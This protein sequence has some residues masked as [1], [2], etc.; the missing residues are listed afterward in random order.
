MFDDERESI[1]FQV[2]KSYHLCVSRL[3]AIMAWSYAAGL[4]LLSCIGANA[5]IHNI[6]AAGAIPDVTDTATMWK[7]G[8]IL[9]NT[10]ALLKSGDTLL[11]PNKTF[12]LYGGITGSGFS[13]VTFQIDGTLSYAN[14]RKTWPADANGNVLQC[15]YFSN[16]ENVLFTSN[17]TGTFDGNGAAWWGAIKYLKY[18]GSYDFS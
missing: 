8:G 6:E 15:M 17:G 12:H 1:S 18:A 13:N 16:I 9:N 5:T 10:I 11:I 3:L 7:N 4:L 14:D 2:T